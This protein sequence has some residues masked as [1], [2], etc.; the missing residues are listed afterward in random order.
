MNA[1][2]ITAGVDHRGAAEP[3]DV[4]LAEVDQV[5]VFVAL[6]NRTREN[7]LAAV[8]SPANQVDLLVFFQFSETG[9]ERL[10]AG[11]GFGERKD[12]PVAVD[13]VLLDDF[14]L[15]ILVEQPAGDRRVGAIA[16]GVHRPAVRQAGEV[17]RLDVAVFEEQEE[18]LG[19]GGQGVGAGV[20][21]KSAGFVV[22]FHRAEPDVAGEDD[23]RPRVPGY[24]GL[25]GERGIWP[26]ATRK[27]L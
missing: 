3:G 25:R 7:R 9:F 15:R 27:E 23:G 6:V 12:Q 5:L 17:D 20:D 2:E 16:P 22:E 19:C 8:F 24:P 18:V 11:G 10:D 26:L 21:E 1:D 13:H 14:L 4:L